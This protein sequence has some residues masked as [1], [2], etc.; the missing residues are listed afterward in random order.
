MA[1]LRD[2]SVDGISL[3]PGSADIEITGL[4]ADSRLVRPGFLFVAV[5]GTRVD[6]ATFIPA[7]VEAGASAVLCAA[8]SEVGSVAVP[9]IRTYDP[10]RAL[11]KMAA[12]FHGRQPDTIVAVTGT[13]GKTSVAD[14]VRQIFSILGRRAASLGTIGLIK[15]D[16]ETYGGL[17]TPDPISLHDT[18]AKLAEDGVTHLAFEASS[19]GLDQRRLDGVSIKAAA[20]TNLGRDHL[21]YHPSVEAY[22]EAKLRLFK[23]LLPDDGVAVI[24]VADHY[25]ERI[26]AAVAAR[27]I[28][29]ITFNG[30]KADLHIKSAE[31]DG[32]A[33]AVEISDGTRSWK[34]RLPLIGRYQAENALAAAALVMAVGENRDEVFS[35]LEMLKG[36]P[37]RL[38]VVG[39]HRDGLVIVDYA[40]KPEALSAALA[41]VR[42]FARGRL[43]CVFGCGGDRDRGKR[44]LMGEIAA[45][46][47]DVVI[48]TDDNPR[49]EDAARIRAEILASSPS[50]IEVPDRREAIARAIGMMNSGDVVLIAGKGHETGQIV[51]DRV[52]PF[53]DRDEARRLV[54]EN[55]SPETPRQ[56]WTWDDLVTAAEA[57]P[58]GEARGEVS[59]FSIDT[60]SLQPGD[61]F[62]ALSDARD[63]HDFVPAAFRAGAVAAL[64]RAGY[65][66][67]PEDGLLLRVDDPL[68]A[69]RRIG[70]AA[71]ARLSDRA[72]VIAVT[73]SA[74]KTS[75]K[76]MLRTCLEVVAPGRVHASV[77]SYN[78]HWGVPLTLARMPADTI[79]AVFEIGMNHA[80]E[81]TPLTKLVRP[82]IAIVT[83]VAA[84]HIEN[85]ASVDDIAEAKAEIFTGL[86]SGGTGIINADNPFSVLLRARA[87]ACGARIV[88][89][90]FDPE[91]DVQ[92]ILGDLSSDRSVVNAA[93]AQGPVRFTLGAPGAHMVA[94]SLAVAAA[95]QACGVGNLEKGLAALEHMR[96]AEGRGARTT[97][98]T[99]AGSFL[100]IDE[101]YN[102]N[103]SSVR[104]ALAAMAL[105]PRTR[106]PR[107]VVVLGDML[108]LGHRSE[109]LH[110]E[111]A[112]EVS[113]AGA[114]LVFAAGPMM[115]A[116]FEAL[117][118]ELQAAWAPS[119][120]ELESDLLS[121]V[122]AGDVVV[123]K[124]S[125]GSRMGP[126]TE[127]LKARYPNADADAEAGNGENSG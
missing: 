2:L 69:L 91:A 106:Y 14:F 67:V 56:I 29:T 70:A 30:L 73:G 100:L 97:L 35:A 49:T 61:V 99:E 17:T 25:G 112:D 108:E 38:E 126:L 93:T 88:T 82:H 60:R 9:V 84:V 124:G 103:P 34:L 3:E 52:E 76:E 59:G 58:D 13:S 42:P 41:S 20:F 105:V 6:G 62:V 115:R 85:F 80:G 32:F 10:R 36:V 68:Q 47:A 4:T 46:D 51:G 111:L 122:T 5:P 63:G 48:V 87:A 43:I 33:Q 24:N 118:P 40:H 117:P 12:R 114:D 54:V 113:G 72:R 31:P 110:R 107:R 127:A 37:G 64:V 109:Q 96:A 119:S 116:M 19:H 15:P 104:A 90:G 26:S 22:F 125:L 66:R 121:T 79:F 7:A 92:G 65:E 53:S 98:R 16:G 21:D 71:R 27:G 95:L 18:L 89:F 83:T 102:A 11:A 123:I 8:G 55:L 1:K 45:R 44:P 39:R 77:K 23:D 50:A 78:N 120:S 75:T 57:R 86:Q 28:R 101:S 74:G 94:N 81:I